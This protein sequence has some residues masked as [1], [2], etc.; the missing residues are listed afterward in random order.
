LS[1]QLDTL[2]EM[3]QRHRL[4]DLERRGASVWLEVF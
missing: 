2:V 1:E 4:A 3:L